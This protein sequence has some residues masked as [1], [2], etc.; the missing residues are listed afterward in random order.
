MVRNRLVPA[1]RKWQTRTPRKRLGASP[2]GFESR[3]RHGRSSLAAHTDVALCWGCL[4][5]VCTRI[6]LRQTKAGERDA[7]RL[8]CFI[9][10]SPPLMFQ[11]AGS[12]VGTH[13]AS[14]RTGLARRPPSPHLRRG[15]QGVRTSAR[16][17]LAR[18]SPRG[19]RRSPAQRPHPRASDPRR[20]FAPRRRGDRTR[21]PRATR[22]RPLGRGRRRESGPSS[23]HVRDEPSGEAGRDSVVT[24]SGWLAH[25]QHPSNQLNVLVGEV[26]V[27]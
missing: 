3:R 10:R 16:E 12:S 26:N 6:L 25:H 17:R 5:G 14:R 13:P 11:Y 15:G 7:L 1:W 18:E 4:R 2:C 19:D 9:R 27:Q 22:P 23:L 8:S 20:G 24:E 21:A